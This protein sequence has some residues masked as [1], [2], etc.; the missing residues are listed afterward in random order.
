MIT[1][2]WRK[3]THTHTVCAYR[4][5]V[6]YSL[7]TICSSRKLEAKMFIKGQSY[8]EILCSSL[9]CP[10]DSQAKI[11]EKN[12]SSS[13]E[14]GRSQGVTH[15]GG[16]LSAHR[17]LLWAPRAGGLGFSTGQGAGPYIPQVN[18]HAIAKST[19]LKIPCAL[20]RTRHNWINKYF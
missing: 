5:R 20:I 9:L 16:L 1:N 15:W 2:V 4:G 7:H 10:W 17:L 18:S 3:G 8:Q 14:K 11:T 19:Q 12:E 6:C 13:C